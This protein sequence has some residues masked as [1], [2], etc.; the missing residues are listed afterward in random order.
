MR[1]YLN[2]L[3]RE[4]SDEGCQ[5]D[6][7]ERHH[8]ALHAGLEIGEEAIIQKE[9]AAGDHLFPD[10]ADRPAREPRVWLTVWAIR[11]WRWPTG[12]GAE[13]ATRKPPPGGQQCHVKKVAEPQQG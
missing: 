4:L 5:C 13:S 2:E 12:A 3:K 6:G 1:L 7:D 10:R 9:M 11:I 8:P